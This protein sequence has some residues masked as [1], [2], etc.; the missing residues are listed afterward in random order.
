M[1]RDGKG[2]DGMKSPRTIAAYLR[3]AL[4]ARGFG[5]WS[6]PRPTFSEAERATM[7]RDRTRC[8]REFEAVIIGWMD[9]NPGGDPMSLRLDAMEVLAPRSPRQCAAC[10][11]KPH[12]GKPHF[13]ELK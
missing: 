2:L 10:T 11:I 12:Y 1:D 8:D 3:D 4:P 6:Q 5:G 13:E 9:G 7:E